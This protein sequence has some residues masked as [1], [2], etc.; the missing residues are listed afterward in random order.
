[1]KTALELAMERAEDIEEIPLITDPMSQGW[2]QPDR[3]EILLDDTHAVMTRQT[4]NRLVEY[5]GSFPSGVYPGKM[6]KRHDGGFDRQFRACGGIP[7]WKLVW[8]G[9]HP[10]P[11][12][13]S[14]NSR[15]IAIIEDGSPIL[16]CSCCRPPNVEQT[17]LD[18]KREAP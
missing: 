14:N 8:F 6:W 2:K 1:M 12:F 15:D 16:N 5:S 7:T 13:V 3:R 9:K 11:K 10:D 18:A 4:F 17:N